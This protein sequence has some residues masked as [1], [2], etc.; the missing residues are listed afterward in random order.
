MHPNLAFSLAHTWSNNSRNNNGSVFI[1]KEKEILFKYCKKQQ[2]SN[3][4]DYY[5]FGHRHIPLELKID[6][7]TTYVNLGDWLTH[8]TYAVLEKGFIQI[9]KHKK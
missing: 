6:D 2:E 3:P 4:V 1:S 9:K 5:I 7:T 8:N